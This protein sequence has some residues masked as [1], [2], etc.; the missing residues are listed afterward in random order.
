MCGCECFLWEAVICVS[1]IMCETGQVG[2]WSNVY[3]YDF[4]KLELCSTFFFH[5]LP[6]LV[7]LL[8]LHSAST[9]AHGNNGMLKGVLT[10]VSCLNVRP[11]PCPSAT[12]TLTLSSHR[13]I[14]THC[15][16]H[17]HWIK[18]HTVMQYV[19]ISWWYWADLISSPY[20]LAPWQ[21]WHGSGLR[22]R[23]SEVQI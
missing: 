17:W 10:L 21:T 9:S 6:V 16:L 14:R 19:H 22:F 12:L 11:T 15:F 20:S 13:T 3:V 4:T 2:L 1:V 23:H 5:P 18:R 7:K 8:L